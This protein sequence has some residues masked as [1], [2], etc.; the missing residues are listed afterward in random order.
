M[1]DIQCTTA[2]NK[3]GRE[4]EEEE[5]EEEPHDENRTKI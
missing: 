5:E 2:E 1:V 4:E 3:R